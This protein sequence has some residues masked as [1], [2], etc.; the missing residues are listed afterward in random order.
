MSKTK[1][2]PEEEEMQIVAELSK[3]NKNLWKEGAV[4]PY[5]LYLDGNGR[6]VEGTADP[7]AKPLIKRGDKITKK[8][9][10]LVALRLDTEEDDVL[11]SLVE[12]PTK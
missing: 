2:T 12:P 6:V 5:A 11:F 4:A 1:V 3:A 9:Q 8:A 10:D 7:N